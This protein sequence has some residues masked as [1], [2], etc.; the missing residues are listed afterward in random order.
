[1]LKGGCNQTSAGR[2][3]PPLERLAMGVRHEVPTKAV[4]DC[5]DGVN[6]YT[7]EHIYL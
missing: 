4:S 1:M 7:E 2:N 6:Y 3:K 5:L